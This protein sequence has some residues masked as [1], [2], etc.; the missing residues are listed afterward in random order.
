MEKI[1]IPVSTQPT[2]FTL[3][4]EIL[5][6][7]EHHA[8]EE[9]HAQCA[10][11]VKQ[12]FKFLSVADGPAGTPRGGTL[13]TA[14]Y[15]QNT[16]N[17]RAVPHLICR[18]STP[19]DIARRADAFHE[20]G[21]TSI[22]A[23]RG[24]PPADNPKWQPGQNGSYKYAS[25][26]V[27]QL[28][29]HE[30][31]FRIGVAAYPDAGASFATDGGNH[32]TEARAQSLKVFKTK[33]EAGAKFAITQVLLSTESYSRFLDETEEANCAV[34]TYAGILI[35]KSRTHAEELARRFKLAISPKLLQAL[36]PNE[37]DS[38]AEVART[39]ALAQFIDDLK[40]AG[41]PGI[42]YFL[43]RTRLTTERTL[44]SSKGFLNN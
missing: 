38:L 10:D 29:A 35:P 18:D 40:R 4:A 5:P 26:L 31:N 16:L 9:V 24:D 32:N 1:E 6:P 34:P 21:I 27:E 11:L 19:E 3:S 37:S 13:E 43:L 44:R 25:Q 28:R 2:S 30:A 33:I 22:L 17:T 36:S 15:I 39:E 20:A 41:A 8:A 14:S 42:H 7:T 23:L 12:G